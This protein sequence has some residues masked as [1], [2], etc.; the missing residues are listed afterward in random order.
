MDMKTSLVTIASNTL[1]AVAVWFGCI[2]GVAGARNVVLFYVW[3]V[4]LPVTLM[5]LVP[6]MQKRVAAK[7]PAPKF[8]RWYSYFIAWGILWVFIWQG[9]SLTGAVWGSCL[10]LLWVVSDSV[11]RRRKTI[12]GM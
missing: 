11:A 12:G 5:S 1:F 7:P 2:V 4:L 6:E 9:Y 3:V 10:F 8:V